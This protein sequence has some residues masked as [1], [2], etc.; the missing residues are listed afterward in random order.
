MIRSAAP[1]EAAIVERFG[2]A[3]ESALGLLARVSRSMSQGAFVYGGAGRVLEWSFVV[4]EDAGVAVGFYAMRRVSA[5][6]SELEALFV[7]PARIGQGIGRALMD[8]AKIAAA[9][10]GARFIGDP[11]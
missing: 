5:T 2:A 8:H 9:A 6:E 3:R 1:G 10:I 11:R 4:A 7:E